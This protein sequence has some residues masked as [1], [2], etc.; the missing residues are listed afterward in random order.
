MF[1]HTKVHCSNC[2]KGT[3]LILLNFISEILE[4]LTL[5]L[6]GHIQQIN[7][8]NQTRGT[9]RLHVLPTHDQSKRIHLIDYK[10][11]NFCTQREI[12]TDLNL[13]KNP[14]LCGKNEI[15]ILY[16]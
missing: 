2:L 5:F 8:F 6:E 15:V 4:F 14:Q 13:Y 16:K 11:I 1:N 12:L 10:I 7:V 3:F 9:K